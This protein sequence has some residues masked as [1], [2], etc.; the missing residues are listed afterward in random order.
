VPLESAMP[1]PKA[2]LATPAAPATAVAPAA[3]VA[4]STTRLQRYRASLELRVRTPA[5][6]S[7]A[8]RRALA[9]ARS[10][11]GYPLAVDVD[12]R[13][14]NGYASLTLR[15][16]RANVQRAVTRLSALGTIVASNVLVEDVQAQV[17]ATDARIDRLQR[18]L[19]ELRAAEK[20]DAVK[21]Q[22]ASLTR[23]VE[24]LQRARAAAVKAAAYATVH[25]QVATRK[26]AA[27]AVPDGTGPFH[28]LGVAFRWAGI[29]AVYALALAAPLV[30]LGFLV[31]LAARAVRR[32]REDA[33][34]SAS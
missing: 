28:G 22:I 5:D 13:G 10:L 3:G 20:T 18:R 17:N 9:I 16:P 8:T 31:W 21:R 30:L 29:V 19:A 1:A 33:L 12:A 15:I 24:R 4:P 6:V 7:A 34:L 23:Q 26:R 14:R 32:R 2:A 25:L 27:A 11:G